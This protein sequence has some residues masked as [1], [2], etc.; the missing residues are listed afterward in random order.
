M[1]QLRTSLLA[2][3]I[4]FAAVAAPAL[5]S[6]PTPEIEMAT[7][8]PPVRADAVYIDPRLIAADPDRYEL[9]REDEDAPFYNIYLRGRVINVTETEHFTSFTFQAY[10]QGAPLTERFTIFIPK[11][12]D[13][14]RGDQLCVYGIPT[15]TSTITYPVSNAQE[16][17]PLILAYD[18]QYMV[19]PNTGICPKT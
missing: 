17:V 1:K 3:A 11:T 4:T 13:L 6:T 2:A 15:G 14:L 7:A 10:V 12:D 8:R 16:V 19:G 9:D 18:A 5:A